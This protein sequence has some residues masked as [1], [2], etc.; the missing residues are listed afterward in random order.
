MKCIIRFAFISF[1]FHESVSE[2]LSNYVLFIWGL[3][4]RNYN[5]IIIQALI[6]E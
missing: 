5:V 2:L 6:F 4:E 3:I 1:F